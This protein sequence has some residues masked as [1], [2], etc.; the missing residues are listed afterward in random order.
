[1]DELQSKLA[2]GR[3]DERELDEVIAA[4]DRVVRDNRLSN[5]DREVLSDDMNRLRAFRAKHE[6]YGA[7]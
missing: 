1:M 5:R 7:R 4:M 3:Y 6:D 2:A